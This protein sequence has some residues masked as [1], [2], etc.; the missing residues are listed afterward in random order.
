MPRRRLSHVV[1]FDDAPFERG[2]RGDVAIVG[3]VFAGSRL[4]GVLSGK[5][6][7]DGVNSTRALIELVG[8]SRFYP[9]LHAIL[10]QGIAFAGF[11]VVDIHGMQQALD[12]PVLVVCRRLPDLDKIRDALLHHVPG[13]RRKWRLIERAGAM[14]PMAGVYVQRAGLSPAAA[15]ALIEDFALHGRLPEPL[16]TAHLIAGG[17]ATGESRHRA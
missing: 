11:N 14:E 5:V 13:G 3:A 16:R 15:A 6:R 8:R 12:R 10:L 17:I 2:H 4:E 1:G 7:R 9:Q